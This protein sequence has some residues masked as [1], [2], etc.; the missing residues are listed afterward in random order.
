MVAGTVL[1]SYLLALVMPSNMG[2]IALLMPVVLAM[3][4]RAGISYE[5][6][7]GYSFP[8]SH[9]LNFIFPFFFGG[10]T[11]APYKIPYWG[12]STIDET[13][14]YFGLMALLLVLA[15]LIGNW[16]KLTEPRRDNCVSV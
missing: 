14:G 16:W 6:F 8:P 9:V 15:A 11:I 1:L 3:G 12:P 4:E 2:R 7:S 5:Y 13:C 10:G